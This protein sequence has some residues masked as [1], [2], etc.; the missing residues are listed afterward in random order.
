[1]S[2][3]AH[4]QYTA[5]DGVKWQ[6][7]ADAFTAWLVQPTRETYPGNP[8]EG[9]YDVYK[10]RQTYAPGPREFA[11]LVASVFQPAQSAPPPSTS[12]GH[13]V[14]MSTDAFNAFLNYRSGTQDQILQFAQKARGGNPVA[15]DL[16][17]GGR[18]GGWRVGGRGGYRG[19]RGGGRG[20]FGGGNWSGRP[21]YVRP[22]VQSVPL[23]GR[24]GNPVNKGKQPVGKAAN[25]KWRYRKRG[26]RKGKA[27]EQP[28]HNDEE[29]EAGPSNVDQMV[30]DD[31]GDN[32]RSDPEEDLEDAVSL[33]DEGF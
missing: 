6:T 17:G 26:G 22:P 33:G 24:V 15:S 12:S 25:K 14:L 19:G 27:A 11:Q 10:K 13:S 30:V 18:Y 3:R 29:P 32:G 21:M 8:P 20:G 16:G 31:E 5:D 1:M 2:Q 23:A 28:V 4:N 9:Y 7:Y